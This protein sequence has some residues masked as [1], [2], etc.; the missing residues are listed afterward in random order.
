MTCCVLFYLSGYKERPLGKPGTLQPAA[1]VYQHLRQLVWLHASGPLSVPPGPRALQRSSVGPPQ[2]VQRPGESVKMTDK[3]DRKRLESTV[4]W[5]SG[6]L[7]RQMDQSV[8]DRIDGTLK[9]VWDVD[10]VA[11]WSICDTVQSSD[12]PWWTVLDYIHINMKRKGPVKVWKELQMIL[13]PPRVWWDTSG[14]HL[15]ALEESLWSGLTLRKDNLYLDSKKMNMCEHFRCQCYCCDNEKGMAISRQKHPRD[16]YLCH[17][18]PS[19]QC[20][21]ALLC[22]DCC[23]GNRSFHIKMLTVKPIKWFINANSYC[24]IHFF[25]PTWRRPSFQRSP[26]H[27]VYFQQ[28]WSNQTASRYILRY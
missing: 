12:R 19:C 24:C 9:T 2:E 18:L 26:E 28:R 25:P 15:G 6:L 3:T 23:R 8:V 21:S 10:K 7:D 13:L 1:G 4:V 14:G 27:T 11:V 22:R 17:A 5:S 20:V 16:W